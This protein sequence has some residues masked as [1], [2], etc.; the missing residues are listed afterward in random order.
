M[1][2]D[3]IN[4]NPW[5]RRQRAVLHQVIDVECPVCGNIVE[6]AEMYEPDTNAYYW[7]DTVCDC[8]EIV[9]GY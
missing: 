4:E 9:E 5:V 3:P 8:G 7:E 2:R 6:C 1:Y